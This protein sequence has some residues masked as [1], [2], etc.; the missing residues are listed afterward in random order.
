VDATRA[1]LL[2]EA[3]NALPAL[4]GWRTQSTST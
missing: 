2:T 1:R 3:R 4:Q